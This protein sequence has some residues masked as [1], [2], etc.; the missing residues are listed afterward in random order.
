MSQQGIFNTGSGPLPPASPPGYGQVYNT[1]A[2]AINNGNTITFDSNGPLLNI[3]HVAGSDTVTVNAAGTY[4]VTW[5]VSAQGDGG[6]YTLLQNG[7][8]V[9][10]LTFVT[11]PGN[12]E[13]VGNGIVN[14]ALGD[15]FQ[16]RNNTGLIIA[17][18]T[19][20]GFA[21]ASISFEKMPS[22]GASSGTNTL[23]G[24]V[25]S[26]TQVAG[27]I[28][29]L[30][31]NSTVLFSG[32]GNTMTL[33]FG[34]ISNL[35]LGSSF[36][37]LA[38]GASNI[39]V[40]RGA[41][42]SVTSGSANVA[43]GLNSQAAN[44]QGFFNTGLGGLTLQSL[45]TGSF[46]TAVGY[47][48]LNK[49]T[50]TDLN[51]AVG[52]TALS[53][54]VTGT[55]NIAIGNGAGGN[56]T[57]NE[58]SNIYLGNAGVITEN[59]VMRLGTDGNGAGQ[60]NTT[61]IAGDVSSVRS[62]TAIAGNITAQLGDM[63]ITSGNLEITTATAAGGAK[64]LISYTG[65]GDANRFISARGTQNF[66]A[67]YQSGNT[68]LTVGSAIGNTG[69]GYQ[70]LEALTLGGANTALGQSAGTAI[71]S[72][73]RNTAIGL[74]ALELLTTGSD[75]IALGQGAGAAY[76]IESGN[77][78]IG[79]AGVAADSSVTRIANIYGTT[80][81]ATNA[82]VVIDNAGKLGTAGGGAAFLTSLTGD[83]GGAVVP[84]ANNINVISNVAALNS[85]QSVTFSGSGSTLT[86]NVTDANFNTIIGKNAGKLPSTA[87][88]NTSLGYG[89]LRAITSADS[90]VAVGENALTTLTSSA[91]NTAIGTNALNL[92]VTGKLNIALG[93]SSGTQY[94]TNESS[95]ILIGNSGVAAESH[96]IRLGTNGAGDGQQSSCFIAGI[97]GVNVGS[98]AKV[99][100]MASNQLGTATITAGTGVT[101]TAGANTIT[102][103]AS[104][105]TNLT[106]TNVN[107]TPY[108]VLATDEYLSVD[109]SALSITVQLPN[110]A[111]SGRVFII[112]DRTGAAATRNITV[113]TVG[114]VVNIDGAA[115][116]VMNTNFQSIQVIGNGS[117]YEI[118]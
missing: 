60:Q 108:V 83:S 86:L 98:V 26:A 30:T 25:G 101:V 37:A 22:G 90:N 92:L 114:G 97:D 9:P 95:N 117:T 69:V 105:T 106:Y 52:A 88:N 13:S 93:A 40:G 46:N 33:D 74:D 7:V 72:G 11:D 43:V 71:T 76:T 10:N 17:L 51:I 3:T 47:T 8:A 73:N 61:V 35:G 39:G 111:T 94:S 63:V 5:I 80:V 103:A 50:T 57:T 67:G 38:G 82:V 23:V 84:T 42:N 41:L 59:N 85:G 79:L 78:A 64:G 29:L 20:A 54:L 31:A 65:A 16:L 118:F 14:V 15:T 1:G 32:A 100:T 44:T 21:N 113:T 36:P 12:G 116:F 68:S 2:Q 6:G 66:F 109:T 62:F 75:N 112:K 70:A 77:I 53:N 87:V 28:N 107:A 81:G 91:S 27:I 18:E 96:V 45:T 48:A 99:V 19:Q 56:L 110:A 104:G 4:M 58:S 115:T 55:R 34:T 24:N 49:L 102:I 89:T